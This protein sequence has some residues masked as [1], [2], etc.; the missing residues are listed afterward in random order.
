MNET[1]S[2]ESECSMFMFAMSKFYTIFFSL[3][4]FKMFTQSFAG[5]FLKLFLDSI[6]IKLMSFYKNGDLRKFFG[7]PIY[8]FYASGIYMNEAFA[9]LT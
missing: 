4:P 7:F 3:F 6:P 1:A 5:S 2:F 9:G 8:Y